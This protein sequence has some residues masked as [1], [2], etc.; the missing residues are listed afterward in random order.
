MIF[1][2]RRFINGIFFPIFYIYEW[3]SIKNHFKFIGFKNSEKFRRDYLVY[4]FF[5]TVNGSLYFHHCFQFDA[6]VN[7][8]EFILVSYLDIFSILY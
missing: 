8:E 6:F 1:I 4:S 5:D 3:N 2:K 7:I